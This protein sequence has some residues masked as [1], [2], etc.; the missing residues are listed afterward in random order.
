M[1]SLI[2]YFRIK[3]KPRKLRKP[4]FQTAQ[5]RQKEAEEER[6]KILQNA[7]DLVTDQS[8][9]EDE[10]IDTP[11]TPDEGRKLLNIE[12]KCCCFPICS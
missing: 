3:V 9:Y 12:Q 6:Q 8:R 11:T 1:F 10:I 2:P 7:F 4:T 5:K